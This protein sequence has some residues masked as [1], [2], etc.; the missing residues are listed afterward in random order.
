MAKSHISHP[1]GESAWKRYAANVFE[2]R[3]D[4]L[5][6]ARNDH[7]GFLIYDMW[8]GSRR[9]YVPDFLVR[10]A[11]GTILALEIKGP[12][13]PQNKA[14]RGV[15]NEWVKAINAAGGFGRWTWDVA[16]KPSEVQD[17]ITK[18]AAIAEA[19]E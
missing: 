12:D 6:Y 13:S 16:F 2:K 14:K 7:L 18:L 5:A 17:I 4:V 8:P 11:G 15:L 3:I 19:A 10:P 1:V 9:R